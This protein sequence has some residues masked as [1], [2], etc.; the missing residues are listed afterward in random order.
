[1][2]MWLPERYLARS[3]TEYPRLKNTCVQL[4]INDLFIYRETWLLLL[5]CTR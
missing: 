1:L 3:T 5:S 2:F 4:G